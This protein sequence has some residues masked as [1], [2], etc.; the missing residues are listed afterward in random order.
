VKTLVE[1]LRQNH[2][3]ILNDLKQ[4]AQSELKGTL[5]EVLEQQKV[6]SARYQNVVDVCIDYLEDHDRA[7]LVQHHLILFMQR[8]YVNVDPEH[9]LTSEIIKRH[10]GEIRKAVDLYFE[11][12]NKYTSEGNH[13]QLD[14]MEAIIQDTITE[15]GDFLGRHLDTLSTRLPLIK[16][17][18]IDY[19]P[20]SQFDIDPD[21][22]PHE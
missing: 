18:G 20:D 21:N 22:W 3:V 12:W 8:Y 11:V 1:E 6:L 10:E 9:P 7:M 4:R 19:D 17:R 16:M 5:Y 15:M 13:G 2:D 14:G